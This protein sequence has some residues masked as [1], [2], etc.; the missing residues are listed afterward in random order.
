MKKLAVVL[1]TA[2]L[3]ISVGGAAFADLNI[4]KSVS[5]EDVKPYVKKER[6]LTRT[7]TVEAVD[8]EHRV[9][10]LKGEQGKIFDVRVVPE[11]KN[12]A[13]L[14]K[15]DMV[16]LKYYEA[17]SAQVYKAGEAP[18]ITEATAAMET[19][20]AGAK[21]G[22]KLAYQATTTATI[23]AIDVKKPAVTLKTADGKTLAVKVQRPKLLANVKVGDEVVI[24]YTEAV[25]ISVTKAK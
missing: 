9:V 2:L 8:V 23:E 11:A 3:A 21:P 6:F 1:T 7:A 5:S 16:T 12:L 17:V 18:K 10:T 25:A 14:K 15:G 22:G 19:A 13:Q 24:T 4:H 20:K